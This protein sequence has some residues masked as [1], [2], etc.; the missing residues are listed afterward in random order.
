M[1]ILFEYIGPFAMI[2]II[3]GFPL[4]L[5]WWLSDGLLEWNLSDNNIVSIKPAFNPYNGES[6]YIFISSHT[7]GP[8]TFLQ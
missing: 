8:L 3:F 5:A 2:A 1:Q 6:G 7:G 4:W